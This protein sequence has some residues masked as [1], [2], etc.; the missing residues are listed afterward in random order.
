MR[1][2]KNALSMLGTLAIGWWITTMAFGQGSIRI[3]EPK[4][5]ESV[6]GEMKAV[7]ERPFPNQGYVIVRLDNEFKEATA[8]QDYLINTRKLTDGPHTL[9]I[10]VRD[11]RGRPIGTTSVT[12]KVANDTAD[13]TGP[14][15]QLQHW[16]YSHYIP[17]KRL[18]RYR[19][20]ADAVGFAVES[21]PPPPAQTGAAGGGENPGGPGGPGMRSEERRVGKE[22]RL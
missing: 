18:L 14:G 6:R 9:T 22:C 5:N 15:I 7:F 11:D 17:T 8:E 16:D 3:L 21:S 20:W 2:N 10:D 12:F 4:P 19:V 1:R 13:T